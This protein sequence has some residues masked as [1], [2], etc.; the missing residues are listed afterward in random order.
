MSIIN[1]IASLRS[2]MLEQ[3]IDGVLIYGTDPHL[4]EYVPNAWRSREWIS[5]FT[6]SYGKVA[7][8]RDSA[9]LWTDSRYFLQAES[10]LSGTGIRM[11]KD[12][13][14]DTI[15][16]DC[17][18]ESELKSG[19]TVSIDGLTIS[20]AEANALEQK[21]SA[22]GITLDLTK[23]LVSL[24][25]E[26][27][28]RMPQSTISDYPVIFAGCNRSEKLMQIRNALTKNGAE[29][30]IICQ[31]DDLAWSFNL[32]GNDISYN[33]L[34]TGY[35]YIDH[36]QAILFVSDEKI[37]VWLIEILELD[38]IHVMNYESIFYVLDQMLS[39]TYY[40]DPERTNSLLYRM[41]KKKCNVIDGLAVTTLLKSIKNEIEIEGMREVHIRD[42]IA[43][44]NFLFWFYEYFEKEKL[45][46]LSISDKL[47]EFRSG[48]INYMGDSFSPIIAFGQHGAIVHYSATTNTDVEIMR[49]GI[50]LFDSGGQYLEG[51]TDITRT[52]ATGKV[53]PKQQT[54]FTLVL[55]GMIQL[56]NV[57]FPDGT[58]GY[59]LDTL[60]RKALWNN[61][62]N[63]GHGTGHGVGHYLSV[64][65]GPMAIRQEYNTEPIRAG[66]I[67][68]NEPGLYREG[69]YG[70]RIENVMV[71]KNERL[72]DFGRFLS[73]EMLTLCPID[74]K[75]I[76]RQLLTNIELDWLNA[77]HTS[78]FKKLSFYLLPDVQK[79]LRIQCAPI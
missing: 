12:R 15:S 24:V 35:G 71:C 77:Y 16:V 46:E 20:A 25:W 78:V 47:R 68:T 34:F 21:L 57:I 50:L 49:D 7:I 45:T 3:N 26:N 6:G 8:T 42:G 17:W 28:P 5:G 73:F 64:H 18:L 53:T 33:P 76:N 36:H 44:V 72:S 22:K 19:S 14:E 1:R 40:L 38:G 67:L 59:S 41:I 66:Q 51:T 52:I 48:Q 29:A 70:I 27:R 31:L 79:W 63:Y 74:R 32:R 55:K 9:V 60:A 61:G 69:E 58:K 37:P 75:L 11:I 56:A 10:Q 2:L 30:T 39:Q 62:L 54:D 43:I 4:S 13:Q 23:C 65:E